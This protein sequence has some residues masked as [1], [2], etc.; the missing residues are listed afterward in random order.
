VE[1]TST[2]EDRMDGFVQSHVEQGKA[3]NRDLWITGLQSTITPTRSPEN[4]AADVE[5]IREHLVRHP[6]ITAVFAEEYNVALLVHEAARQIKKPIPEKLSILSV[7]CPLDL[8]KRI[9]Y[10]HIRQ[11]EY[12]MGVKAVHLIDEQFHG[13]GEVIKTSLPADLV[14]GVSTAPPPHKDI[15]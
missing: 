4:V 13:R 2:I 11:H 3:I 15:S 5:T 9:R 14:I 1:N 10:T 6:E 12:E 8:V 7:D